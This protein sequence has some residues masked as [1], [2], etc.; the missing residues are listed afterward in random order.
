RSLGPDVVD[1]RAN[2]FR[3]RNA[4]LILQEQ[5]EALILANGRGR[6]ARGVIELDHALLD[7]LLERLDPQRRVTRRQSIL[8]VAD[9]GIM[10]HQSA[11]TAQAKKAQSLAFRQHPVVVP[12]EQQVATIMRER[13]RQ[14]VEQWSLELAVRRGERGPDTGLEGNDIE[15]DRGRRRNP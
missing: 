14:I 3:R 9:R 11:I 12:A 10:F 6:L 1:Q 4:K 15:P 13:A 2:V 8:D 5:R 7:Q